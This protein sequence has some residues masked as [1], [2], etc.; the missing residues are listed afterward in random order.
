MTTTFKNAALA[1]VATALLGLTGCT[2]PQVDA[3][4]GADPSFDGL[5]P[6]KGTT[7][8]K[9]WVRPGLD[10]SGYTKVKLVGA[11]IQ[12]RP[13]EQRAGGRSA[14]S[15]QKEFAMDE[16]QKAALE[17]IITEEFDK[18]L[19]KQTRFEE[20][21]EPGPD[22]LLVRGAFLDV[23]SKVPPERPGRTDYYLNSVGQATFMVEL[24]DSQSN[25]VLVRA[26]DS[27]A[28]QTPGY[29][30]QS[31]SVTNSAEARRLFARWA[32]MLVD[33]LN[34]VSTLD[35]MTHGNN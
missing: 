26:V 1:A 35:S 24:I 2:T 29:T 4:T 28:A 13:V 20:V 17:R 11:G 10:L 25:S 15:N 31:N 33:A 21:A 34:E 22:V 14:R 8:Q 16:A 27:R 12:Y 30:Y 18:A 3:G 32:T 7:M 5:V 9:V 23:V 19:D 6:L